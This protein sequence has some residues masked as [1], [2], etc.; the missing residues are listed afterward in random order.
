MT[1]EASSPACPHHTF[2]QLPFRLIHVTIAHWFV[3]GLS[4]ITEEEACT[5]YLCEGVSTVAVEGEFFLVKAD[6]MSI[7][8]DGTD[9]VTLAGRAF[10]FS[11][12]ALTVT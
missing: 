5:P 12:L 3:G 1:G 6:V 10:P 8:V 11:R 2:N 7:A 4:A 9:S